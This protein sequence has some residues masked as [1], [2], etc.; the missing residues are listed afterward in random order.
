[1]TQPALKL[2]PAP[3]SLQEDATSAAAELQRLGDV[4]SSAR[5]R[6][7]EVA[8]T[9]ASAPT[10]EL[11]TEN[12]VASQIATNAERELGAYA[13]K[14]APLLK[15]AERERQEERLAQH[16]E[17]LRTAALVQQRSRIADLLA[18]FRRDM[19]GA[20]LDLQDAIGSRNSVAAEATK[21]ATALGRPENFGAADVEGI[22]SEITHQQ[23]PNDPHGDQHLGLSISNPTG[24]GARAVFVVAITESLGARS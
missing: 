6:A 8:A 1:M 9:F 19:R 17:L 16:R 14:I 4:A 24:N 12:L 11:A 20:L 22:L 2:A 7:N 5:A 3:R 15:S 23:R 10:A 13:D 21:L 18:E